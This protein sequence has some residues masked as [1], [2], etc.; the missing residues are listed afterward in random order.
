MSTGPAQD[1][2]RFLEE[3]KRDT[4]VASHI[5]AYRHFPP[6]EA[7][8]RELQLSEPLRA[9]LARRGIERFWSH[10]VEGIEAVRRGEHVVV[11]TPTASGKSLIYNI[12]IVETFLEHPDA[13]A[14]YVFPL[15]G[16]EHDQVAK[17]NRLLA[18]VG[19]RHPPRPR[20]RTPLALAEVYDGE[21]SAYRRKK[22]R[23]QR[24]RAICTNPDMLH[25]AFN[26]FHAKWAD[27]FRNLRF[28]VIDEIHSYR[29]V[30]G[31][32][33]A[34]VFRR[35]R[36]MC[37]AYGSTPRFIACSATIANPREL[38]ERLTDLPFRAVEESGAPQGEKHVLFVN[39]IGSPYTEST[40]VLL[41]SLRAGLRTIV[42]TKARIITELMYRWAVA[43][44]GPLATKL[45][46]Y[47]AGFLPRERRTIEQQLFSGELL[48][49]ISTSAL[50][51]GVDI[52]GLDVCVL[53]GYP[54]SIASTW[55]RAGRVGRHGN[56]AVIVLVALKD[57]LDQYLMHNPEAFFEKG[58]EAV[59]IDPSNPRLLKKHLPCAAAEMP[60][61]ASDPIYP[62]ETVRS[63]LDE[64]VADGV[65]KPGRRGDIWFSKV[66]WPQRTVG[67]RTI[68]DPLH[69]VLADTREKIGEL[70]AA[71][72][73]Q[74]AF[75]GAIYLHRGRQYRIVRLD[76]QGKTVYCTPT[77]VGYYTQALRVED[78]TILDPR[79]VKTT[80]KWVVHWG[81]LRIR[82][83][84]VGYQKRR[85][86]DGALL[87]QHGL[88][89]PPTSFET[90]GLWLLVDPHTLAALHS[91][92]FEIGGSLHAM[93]H[94]AIHCLPLFMLCDNGDIGGFSYPSY[95]PLA[96]P[97]IFIYDGYE[98][99]LGL[100]R[101]ALDLLDDWL[102]ATRRALR[103]CPCPDGCP[104][105]VQDPQC[106]SGNTPLDKKGALF[107]LEEG[108][109]ATEKDL[110][111]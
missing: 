61:R 75:P 51:L 105:C 33:A 95:P 50:E 43:K 6:T 26:P 86:F 60:L 52:G 106:G 74:E 11:M 56:A 1:V 70:D 71:R 57:A 68:G 2:T 45:R 10:Q 42:F 24:P 9:A 81:R 22:I 69:I 108:L 103:Q 64:L 66:K 46:P 107:L 21:T 98:G 12:P 65:L 37:H 79:L 5:A 67:I 7:A 77:D 58:Y 104:S 35:L 25:L 78:T 83:R 39:P 63:V 34:H 49:V 54:G 8:Y 96:R 3:L 15:K 28:V 29:G 84:V 59:I 85:L 55:Q 14:L 102:E 13:T 101:R 47:R 92:G 44:A 38:A 97:V 90:E 82:H 91:R 31:S 72:V 88:A 4:R 40:R 16:L 17:L 76:L 110:S 32:N 111:L 99:G 87:A 80:G 100:T 94:V 36:R 73:F 41:K 53:V 23:E 27:F 18:D 93:E 19:L 48:G 62:I 89:L 30:F 20:E 109:K